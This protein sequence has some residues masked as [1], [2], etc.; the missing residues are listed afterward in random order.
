M[1]KLLLRRSRPSRQSLFC[2]S[3]LSLSRGCPLR[4]PHPSRPCHHSLY[5]SHVYVPAAPS[6]KPRL[7]STSAQCGLKLLSCGGFNWLGKGTYLGKYKCLYQHSLPAQQFMCLFWLL[8]TEV[9][10]ILPSSFIDHTS[11]HLW[12]PLCVS[13]SVPTIHSRCLDAERAVTP[14]LAWPE[15]LRGA[16]SS[17][18]DRSLCSFYTCGVASASLKQGPPNKDQHSYKPPAWSNTNCKPASCTEDLRGL[19]R[20]CVA[21]ACRC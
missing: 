7:G 19:R 12:T 18:Q 8:A 3:S 13:L 16:P 17:A 20:K 9:F 1:E 5:V 10:P 4:C 21:A 15:A 14:P 6:T 11:S 2:F